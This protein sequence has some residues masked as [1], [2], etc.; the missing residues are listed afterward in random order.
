[1]HLSNLVI[2]E[3]KSSKI[4]ECMVRFNS[5]IK[6]QFCYIE[7]FSREPVNILNRYDPFIIGLLPVAMALGENLEIDEIIDIQL[8][9]N[10]NDAIALFETWFPGEVKKIEILCK[11]Y[12]HDVRQGKRIMSFFSGGVDAMFNCVYFDSSYS[13]HRITDL[14]LVHGM[15]IALGEET[16]WNQTCAKLGETAR[17][18][19]KNLISV[20]TNL[21]DFQNGLVNYTHTG[22]GPMLGCI[23]NLLSPDIGLSLIGSYGLFSELA[24]HASGPLVDRLWSSSIQNVTHFTPRFSRLEKIRWIAK[25]NQECLKNLRVCWKNPE[26][27]YNCGTCEKCLRTRMELKI[28]NAL[29]IVETFPDSDIRKDIKLLGKGIP[30]DDI[31][32]YFFWK[33]IAALEKDESIV[34]SIKKSLLSYKIRRQSYIAKNLIKKTKNNARILLKKIVISIKK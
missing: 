34:A 31:Y 17:L 4:L 23:S 3:T 20:K 12:T 10:L 7:I 30:E 24:P 21:R 33:E 1:M 27:S 22:F 14:V 16:L 2:R 13:E 6:H 8:H 15:D 9:N 25:L 29:D 26:G 18:L 11:G 5:D 19:G 32:T 28:L